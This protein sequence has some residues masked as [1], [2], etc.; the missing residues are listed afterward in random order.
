MH[1][2]DI[3][4]KI[5]HEED[6]S[7]IIRQVAFASGLFQGDITIRTLLES[8]AEG[9]VIID[10]AGTILLVNAY[11]SQ[12]FGYEEMELIG[13]PHAV[14]IPE[15][16]REIHQEHQT[17]F[18]AE[19]KIRPM[20][21]LLTLFGRR[22]DG[23][24]FPLE[25]SLSFIKTINGILAM[26]FISDIT[27]RKQFEDDIVRL[28]AKLAEQAAEMEIANQELEAFNFTV[29]HDIR[30][31]LNLLSIYCQSIEMLCGD[32][33]KE[34]CKGNIQEAIKTILQM[35]RFINALLNLSLQ[36]HA[37]LQRQTVDMSS[38]AHEV[39]NMLKLTTPDRQVELR[40]TDGVVVNADADMLRV[41]FINLIG[42]AWK[43][44]SLLEKTVIEVGS[45][46]IDGKPVYFVRDN[47]AGFDM[48]E[49]DKLFIPFKRL[50]GAKN[51]EGFGVGLATVGRIIHRH[52]GKV[53]AESE[54]DKGATFYFTLL[55]D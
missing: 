20:G 30:Q 40:I 35:N 2:S 49:A 18:F 38:I 52:G 5:A 22:K 29:A 51:C 8:L 16:F 11:A 54:L 15:L 7:R 12:M 31:P 53:W 33:L 39:T 13:N 45:T 55:E 48:S 9:V 46:E 27:E 1:A 44:T 3:D 25:I 23:S 43:Y 24:E 34:E 28:N 4:Q 10:N 17:H 32:Q 37:D 47:G 50:S 6:Q 19:P 42:N 26:A 41:V 36:N 21:K 14:L